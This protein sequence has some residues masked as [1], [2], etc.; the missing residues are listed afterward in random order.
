MIILF[1]ID[2]FL[3]ISAKSGCEIKT[4]SSLVKYV[5]EKCPN[6]EFTGLMTIGE[7]GYDVSKGPNPDFLTLKECKIKVCNELNLDSKIVELS[8][9]MSTDFEHAVSS[10]VKIESFQSGKTRLY[11][12]YFFLN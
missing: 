3:Y 6:L 7:Y 4:T 12:V 11:L 10:F 5:I 8:M 9:G 1:I 2:Q